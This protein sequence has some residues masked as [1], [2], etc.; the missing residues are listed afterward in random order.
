MY[1]NEIPYGGT[2]W[3][4]QAASEIYFDKEVSE[5]NLIESAVLAGLPQRPTAYSPF[6]DDNAYI[7][8]TTQVLRRMREDGYITKEQEQEALN[9]WRK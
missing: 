8:R 5:L 2:A 9:S 7:G 3:G 6:N 1:L 4:A